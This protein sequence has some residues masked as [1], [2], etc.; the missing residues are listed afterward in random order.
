MRE[1]ARISLFASRGAPSSRSVRAAL[2][3]GLILDGEVRGGGGGS[4]VLR[5][6][7]LES[8]SGGL[9]RCHI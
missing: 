2:I 1:P 9:R 3:G 8:S 4:G 5:G 7:G 6:V